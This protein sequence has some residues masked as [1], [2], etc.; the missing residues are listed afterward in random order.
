MKILVGIVPSS[1]NRLKTILW[2]PRAGFSFRMFVGRKPNLDAYMAA[3]DHANYDQY[4]DLKYLSLVRARNPIKYGQPRGYDLLLLIPPDLTAWNHN[5]EWD[6]MIIEYAVD[7]AAMRT[8]FGKD[9]KKI[10]HKFDNG[11]IMVRL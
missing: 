10:E 4:L 1:P 3:I 6:E 8:E 5:P 9:L 7:V 2:A 11:A